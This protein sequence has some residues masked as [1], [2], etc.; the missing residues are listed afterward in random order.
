MALITI[1]GNIHDP[2]GSLPSP[3]GTITF[4][5]DDWYIAADNHIVIPKSETAPIDIAAGAFSIILESTKDGTPSTRSYAVSVSAT[6]EGTLITKSLGNV[7]LENTPST[8]N[9]FDL[10]NTAT[11]ASTAINFVDREVPSGSINDINKTFNLVRNIIVGSEYV[12]LNDQLLFPTIQYTISGKTI[13]MTIPPLSGD[14][15]YV[16]YRWI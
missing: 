8:Q 9:L 10:L 4:G 6:I 1:I 13:T 15:L 3:A 11:T 12:Y 5:L 16:S 7:Q 2:N 14:R